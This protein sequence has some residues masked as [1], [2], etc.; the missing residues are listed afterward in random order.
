MPR[1]ISRRLVVRQLYR[2][3]YFQWGQRT[4]ALINTSLS[5]VVVWSSAGRAGVK[6]G[7]AILRPLAHAWLLRLEND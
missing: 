6:A 3:D 5:Y 2:R 1:A 7:V 4:N